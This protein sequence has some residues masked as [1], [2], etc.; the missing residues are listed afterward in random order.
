MHLVAFVWTLALSGCGGSEVAVTSDAASDTSGAETHFDGG[1]DATPTPRDASARTPK[2]HRPDAIACAPSKGPGSSA[3]DS[4]AA[5]G[6]CHKDSEC[7]EGLSGKCLPAAGGT[8]TCHCSYDTCEN[9]SHCADLGPC[10]CAGSPYQAGSNGC[11]PSGNC[12]VDADCGEP[13]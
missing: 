6:T 13:G 4:A 11:A 8:L 10:A 5:S 9:D 2:N 7:T 1:A 3:C 12:K